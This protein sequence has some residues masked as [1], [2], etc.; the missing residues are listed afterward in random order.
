M[1][2]FVIDDDEFFSECISS[3]IKK[4]DRNISVKFF[5]NAIDATN[6]LSESLPNLIFLDILLPGPDG[7]AFLNE[8]S[9]YPDTAKIPVILVTG[10][11]LPKTDLSIYGVCGIL[12]KEKMKPEE[13]GVYVERYQN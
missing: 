4:V 9:S 12:D 3:A 6:A 11:K 7:F 5:K 1:L 2:V 8:I 10:L 13:I